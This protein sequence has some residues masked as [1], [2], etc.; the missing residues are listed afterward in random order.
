[1]ID[2]GPLAVPTNGSS[3]GFLTTF[4]NKIDF[5]C[6]EGFFLRGSQT[7]HCEENGTWSGNQTFCQGIYSYFCLS[8]LRNTFDLDMIHLFSFICCKVIKKLT[9]VFFYSTL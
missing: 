3:I 8:E 5:S 1:M 6:D 4:P 9:K 7:R 2:C